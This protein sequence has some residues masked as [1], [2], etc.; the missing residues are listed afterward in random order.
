MTMGK[1]DRNRIPDMDRFARERF[2]HM[3]TRPEMYAK[4]C[5]ELVVQVKVMLEMLGF[6]E[7]PELAHLDSPLDGEFAHGFA[8]KVVEEALMLLDGPR[9]D[10]GW[11]SSKP[12]PEEIHSDCDLFTV[13]MYDQYDGWFDV[14]KDVTASEARERWMKE[15]ANGTRNTLYAHVTYYEIFPAGTRMVFTPD[16]MDP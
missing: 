13:R 15:T 11:P 1:Y 8:Q 6:Q 7:I 16:V 3:R 12:R 9:D 4:H 10:D 14:L 2:D 5:G